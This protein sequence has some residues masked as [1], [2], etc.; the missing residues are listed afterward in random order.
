MHRFVEPGYAALSLRMRTG[1]NPG[2]VFDELH[3]RGQVVIYASEVE[4]SEVLAMV[5]AG[6]A[7]VVADTRQQVAELNAAI[8]EHSHVADGSTAEII[9]DASD[10]VGLGDR[11]TTRRNDPDLQIANRQT[12]KV[13]GVVRMAASACAEK[14]GI[15]R[16]QPTTRHGSSNSPTPPVGDRRGNVCK[17]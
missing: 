15:V 14:A 5:G 11:V 2:R 9:T 8:R 4:R 10:R 12:W 7:L 16:C 3:R 1:E 13:T 6:G 17:G